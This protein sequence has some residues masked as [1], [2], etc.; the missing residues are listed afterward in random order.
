MA[1]T[2]PSAP[3]DGQI[4]ALPDGSN[5]WR[6]DGR[7]WVVI[8]QPDTGI[9][10]LTGDVTAGPGNGVQTAALAATAVTPGSYTSANI[11]VD[12]KG[13]LTLAANGAGGGTIAG[14]T[15]GTGLTGGGTSGTVT[16]SLTTPVAIANGGTGSVTAPAALA[17]L[18]GISGNQTITL[19][20]AV[21][22][23][24][25]TA[26]TATLATVPIASGGTNATTA[27]A[28][29]TNL[30]AVAK[31]GDTMSGKLAVNT[32]AAALQPPLNAPR[33]TLQLSAADGANTGLVIDA[34]A[35]G[36]PVID[37]RGSR[38]TQAVPSPSQN[39]DSLSFIEF[40]GRGTSQFVQTAFITCVAAETFTDTA[41]GSM[42]TIGTADPGTASIAPSLRVRRGVMIGNVDP[43]L[44]P[45][46][47]NLYV[48]G[49]VT[50]TGGTMTGL[51]SIAAAGSTTNLR[52]IKVNASDAAD[53]QGYSHTGAP[54][55]TM[56][57]AGGEAESTGNAGTDFSLHRHTDDG[58]Y[59]APALNINRA[60]GN[61]TFSGTVTI[62]PGSGS[63]NVILNKVV[64]TDANAVVGQRGGL[65][66]WLIKPGD[67]G[68][69]TG[70]DAGSNFA[71]E[72]YADSGAF[73]ATA[74]AIT[75]S[76]GACYNTSGT[77]S[78]LSDLE[79]KE[80][81]EPY[82][83]GLDAILQLNPV[84]FRYKSSTP[85]A[86]EDKPSQLLY[87]LVAQDVEPH[88]P[89][90]VGRVTVTVGDM[91]REVATLNGGDI[92][93]VLINAVKELKA[94][95]DE[96]KA[97]LPSASPRA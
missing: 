37:L 63:A 18:G 36:G 45:G 94:E 62:A 71:I 87:G 93:Y 19:S 60:T 70:A 35:N 67:N 30:G 33:T 50:A 59:L 12:A 32:N 29:L 20:G 83:R 2:F 5:S 8:A 91:D 11:T 54:R 14:V 26:I 53:I 66:R 96:L 28:A 7:H 17:S 51:L 22:G 97:A 74:M 79:L 80:D 41:A 86:A 55:W 61:A 47:G 78:S 43:T 58:S 84:S 44:D 21:S 72:R 56:Y 38:G 95:L 46:P 24:G 3:T 13:R 39:G 88:I 81:V 57:L 65:T 77:W 73:L 64:A 9:T 89:E 49:T 52:L 90:V 40:F 82:T 10:Q 48:G 27:P 15:A 4:Y 75:R 23:T 16:V 76:N 1:L 42:I 68:N 85:F 25:T 34:Y 92:I 69:E 6:Y 31:A